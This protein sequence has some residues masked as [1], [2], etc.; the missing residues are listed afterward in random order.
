MGRFGSGVSVPPKMTPE[1]RY[2]RRLKEQEKAD[3]FNGE[4]GDLPY[5]DCPK[6]KNKGGMLIVKYVDEYDD[7]I[8]FWRDCECMKVR[9]SRQLTDDS[10]L[11]KMQKNY[12]FENYST[13]TQW[14]ENVKKSALEYS[15]EK[16]AWFYI[17]GQSGS[18]K[19]HICTAIASKHLEQ[20]KAV[21]YFL[22][23]ENGTKLKNL[24]SSDFG[25]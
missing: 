16:S 5:Y 12:T 23:R 22:W 1:E 19:T 21:R 3:K 18:G 10:G 24:L 15:K 17:G 6:C 4:K 14:Q 11:K 2:E 8:S 13:D 7:Y 25:R 9:R 20:G